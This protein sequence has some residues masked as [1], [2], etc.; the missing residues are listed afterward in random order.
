MY[1]KLRNFIM[2]K[3]HL[4]LVEYWCQS[5]L[6]WRMIADHRSGLVEGS[7][8]AGAENLMKFHKSEVGKNEEER[9]RKNSRFGEMTSRKAMLLRRFWLSPEERP[10]QERRSKI[11]ANKSENEQQDWPMGED[12]YEWWAKTERCL[13]SCWCKT[14][15]RCLYS[16]SI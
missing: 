2:N 13:C 4:M 7:N 12:A 8:D 6:R 11:K 15:L 16:D 3:K 14:A 9:A 1:G 10:K 5:S